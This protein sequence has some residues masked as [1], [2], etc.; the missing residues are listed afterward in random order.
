MQDNPFPEFYQLPESERDYWW[1]IRSKEARAY[2]EGDLEQRG[3]Y[4]FLSDMFLL[5]HGLDCA[6]AFKPEWIERALS[7]DVKPLQERS[8]ADE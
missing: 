1:G 8:I 2:S 6:P 4:V 3:K 7:N 5:W